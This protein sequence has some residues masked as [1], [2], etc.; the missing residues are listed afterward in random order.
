MKAWRGLPRVPGKTGDMLSP[1]DLT[2][3]VGARGT[4]S[5]TLWDA[6]Q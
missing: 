2:R 3:R 4:D 6:V 1:A 5:A